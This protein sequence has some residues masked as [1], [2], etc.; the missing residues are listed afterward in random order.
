ME[1]IALLKFQRMS[2]SKGQ[3]LAR[4]IQGLPVAEALKIVEFSPRKAA[5]LLHKTLKSAIANAQ[6]NAKL[7]VDNLR[8]KEAA[9]L[10]GPRMKRY[11]PRSRGM[12][13]PILKRLCHIKIVLTDEANG[14]RSRNSQPEKRAEKES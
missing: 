12:V 11:W 14:R 1:V 13:S 5:T 3:Q 2:A 7:P 9:V 10:E 8:V 4:M 6:N